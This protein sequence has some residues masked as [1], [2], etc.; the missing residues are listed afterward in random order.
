MRLN[1]KPKGPLKA[2]I[3]DKLGVRMGS[4]MKPKGENNDFLF[5]QRR[6]RLLLLKS[7]KHI[8]LLIVFC[9]TKSF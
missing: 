9:R 3:C 4:L 1:I 7:F 5:I 2:L 8:E 6:Y